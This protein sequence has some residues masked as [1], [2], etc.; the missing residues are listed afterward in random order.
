MNS[1]FKELLAAFNACDVAYLVVG[2]YAV[3]EYAEP[4][5]TKDI[6]IWIEACPVNARKVYAALRDFGAPVSTVSEDDFAHEG[7]FY[8]IGVPPVRVD[9]LMSIPG[10]QFA[11]AWQRRNGIKI[12]Q[13]N[14]WFISPQDLLISKRA[15][16]RPQDLLDAEALELALRVSGS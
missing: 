10:L 8:Q 1:D 13:T 7:Y 2:G 11:D 9:I 4:R 16:G 12:D 15:A 14:I 3:I 5:F 6:D